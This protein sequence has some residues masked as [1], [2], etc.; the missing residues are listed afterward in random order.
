M[1]EKLTLAHKNL[2]DLSS[3]KFEGSIPSQFG[4][5]RSLKSLNLP[6]ICLLVSYQLNE[7]QGG[8]NFDFDYG[9]QIRVNEEQGDFDSNLLHL[10]VSI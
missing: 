4:G 8:F 9:L 1:A 7:E 6:I 5:L 3:N 10:C 2:R